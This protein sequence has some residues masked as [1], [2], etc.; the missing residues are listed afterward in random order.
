MMT[1]ASALIA[2]LK[3][4]TTE[5]QVNSM[6]AAAEA[7]NALAKMRE[8]QIANLAAPKA[9]A[10]SPPVTGTPAQNAWGYASPGL[11]NRAPTANVTG[12]AA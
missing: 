4:T 6:N 10:F 1:G 12:A 2:G 8:Q 7:N 5:A 3:P 11:I 9:V